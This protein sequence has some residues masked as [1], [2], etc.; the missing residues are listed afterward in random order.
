ME[1]WERKALLEEK[2]GYES[3]L[4]GDLDAADVADLNEKITAVDAQLARGDRE[5]AESGAEQTPEGQPAEGQEQQSGEATGDGVAAGATTDT[6]GDGDGG[7]TE[8]DDN[9]NG[10]ED[11]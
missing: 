11:E 3:K 4:R 7:N 10:G 2:A 9:H 5:D 1:A 8:D 6:T